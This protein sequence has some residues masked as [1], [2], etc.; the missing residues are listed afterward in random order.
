MTESIGQTLAN[1]K[2]VSPKTPTLWMGAHTGLRGS[3]T[4]IK[5]LYKNK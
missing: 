5:Y 3:H 1:P 2:F 4:Y